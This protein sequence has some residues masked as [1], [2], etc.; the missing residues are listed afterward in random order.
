M[1]RIDKLADML[2]ERLEVD[3]ESIAIEPP[4]RISLTL[5]QVEALLGMEES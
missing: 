3:P 1:G 2:A 4:N 5:E